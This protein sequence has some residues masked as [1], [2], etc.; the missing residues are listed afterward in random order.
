MLLVNGVSN[1]ILLL[2]SKLSIKSLGMKYNFV[3]DTADI[4][5]MCAPLSCSTTGHYSLLLT[6]RDVDA[7]DTNVLHLKW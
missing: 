1:N 4:P 6:M 3:N 2:I 7:D 5:G